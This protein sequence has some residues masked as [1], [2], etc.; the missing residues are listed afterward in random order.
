MLKHQLIN[1]ATGAAVCRVVIQQALDQRYLDR[2]HVNIDLE[3]EEV[4]RLRYALDDVH[5]VELVPGVHGQRR[6]H[7]VVDAHEVRWQ[8]GMGVAGVERCDLD[9]DVLAE[10]LA[11][12]VI[13][14]VKVPSARS[15][16]VAGGAADSAPLAK[17][18]RAEV[19]EDVL[20][21]LVHGHAA[22]VVVLAGRQVRV[23]RRDAV[24]PPQV[25][26]ALIVELDGRS[27]LEV[28][29]VRRKAHRHDG[30]LALPE[31]SVIPV[32]H[33]Q[34][35]VPAVAVKGITQ[36]APQGLD[37]LHAAARGRAEG[38][39]LGVVACPALVHAR[40]EVVVR[41]GHG[42]G[43][44]VVIGPSERRV[45]AQQA[46]D[47]PDNLLALLGVFGLLD[48]GTYIILSLVDDRKPLLLVF[49][50]LVVRKVPPA[51][52][53]L[54]QLLEDELVPALLVLLLRLVA[55]RAL[56]LVRVVCLVLLV[57]LECLNGYARIVE[58]EQNEGEGEHREDCQRDANLASVQPFV[59]CIHDDHL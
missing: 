18:G 33:Y 16:R 56:A 27:G 21:L 47:T 44:R 25:L 39:E 1:I 46:L 53:L 20:R 54:L 35:L 29:R 17:V 55:A 34:P 45:D 32:G 42:M 38:V 28:V 23:P 58:V 12:V 43:H 24:R 19:H 11:P 26:P 59:K 7:Q 6:V 14:V 10:R 2:G 52:L 15:S 9:G 49:A 22:V 48:G 3:D 57:V 37:E 51:V 41:L 36:H 5:G 40:E 50:G 4:T 30:L 31:V 13:R 8:L